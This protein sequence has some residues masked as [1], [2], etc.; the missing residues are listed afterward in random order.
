M[1]ELRN[2]EDGVKP[3]ADKASIKA[4]P[5]SALIRNAGWLSVIAIV[6]NAFVIA[7][8]GLIYFMFT[9]RKIMEEVLSFF[10]TDYPSSF[11][12]LIVRIPAAAFFCAS[13]PFFISAYRGHFRFSL[14]ELF[15]YV[16]TA[17][18][19]I[20]VVLCDK[21]NTLDTLLRLI[22]CPLVTG[23]TAAIVAR[24]FRDTLPTMRVWALVG[25]VLGFLLTPE[26]PWAAVL[27]CGL[28]VCA[29]L[30]AHGIPSKR[31]S[32]AGQAGV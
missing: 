20:G 24:Q 26:R 18:A 22:G 11:F 30:L 23:A 8:A 31:S 7:L 5:E 29:C 16:I 27:V 32:E 4:Q 9:D 6:A 1:S 17:G 10:H 12:A 19:V 28:C 21:S 25:A 3:L 15:I 2:T 13:A 14:V